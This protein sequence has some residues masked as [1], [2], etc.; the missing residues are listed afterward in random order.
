MGTNA[1]AGVSGGAGAAASSLSPVNL[2]V[3]RSAGAG[4]G[5]IIIGG[6]LAVGVAICLTWC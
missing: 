1:N 4:V 6:V 5:L 2:F 3:G